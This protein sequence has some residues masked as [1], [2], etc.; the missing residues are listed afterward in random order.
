MIGCRSRSNLL[1]QNSKTDTILINHAFHLCEEQLFFIYSIE[2]TVECFGIHDPNPDIDPQGA[3]RRLKLKLPSAHIDKMN[4][5]FKTV[6]K[7]K[8]SRVYM[9]VDDNKFLGIHRGGPSIK[10]IRISDQRH[11]RNSLT[12]KVTVKR[13]YCIQGKIA[14]V[15]FSP[16]SP[17]NMRANLKLG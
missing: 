6:I 13:T 4:N 16:F 5:N 1:W 14:P 7:D 2:G 17:S 15:L 3:G 11:G 8:K 12:I 10:G 9:K